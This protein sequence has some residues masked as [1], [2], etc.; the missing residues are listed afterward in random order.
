MGSARNLDQV[1]ARIFDVAVDA[2]R[3]SPTF[4]QWCGFSLSAENKRQAW[5]PAGFAHGFTVRS[6]SAEMLY[7]TT[8]YWA[9]EHERCIRWDDP[10]L[11]I[12]WP[13]AG[14]VGPRLAPKDA[15]A[16]CFADAELPPFVSTAL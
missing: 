14:S 10:Q 9:P 4:G 3:S 12:P 8:D 16:P 6:E 13:A 2:R 5:I 7:K 1:A 11:A 15:A